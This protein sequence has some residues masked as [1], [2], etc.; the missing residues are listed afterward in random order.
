MGKEVCFFSGD[1]FVP[2]LDNESLQMTGSVLSSGDP[3]LAGYNI[4][5]SECGSLMDALSVVSRGTGTNYQGAL[6]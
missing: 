1:D 5:G 3:G 6:Q 2:D 4:A